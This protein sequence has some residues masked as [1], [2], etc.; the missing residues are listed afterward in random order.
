MNI[1]YYD[2]KSI[3]FPEPLDS[4]SDDEKNQ[5]IMHG[6]AATMTPESIDKNKHSHFISIGQDQRY[7]K[8]HMIDIY[9]SLFSDFT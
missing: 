5:V 7:K 8:G 4:D 1:L 3:K 2:K 6:G 9:A